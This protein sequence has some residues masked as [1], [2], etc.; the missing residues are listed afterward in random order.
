MC[1][2]QALTH[3]DDIVKEVLSIKVGILTE[4]DAL[5]GCDADN[6]VQRQIEQLHLVIGAAEQEP[7]VAELL[8]QIGVQHILNGPLLFKGLIDN[9][10]HT[11]V[12]NVVIEWA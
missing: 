2:F 3:A 7:T 4:S 9:M 10:Q 8:E 12:G 5:G 1:A 11:M 6:A